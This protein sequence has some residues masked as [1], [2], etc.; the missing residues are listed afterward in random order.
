MS[1]CMRETRRFEID[2]PKP[3]PPYSCT[4]VSKTPGKRASGAHPCRGAVCLRERIEDE[5]ELVL[6]DTDTGVQYTELNRDVLAVHRK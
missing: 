5:A 1:P 2:R 3:V 4:P 6:R